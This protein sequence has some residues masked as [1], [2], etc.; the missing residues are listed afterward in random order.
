MGLVDTLVNK[1]E[2]G[3]KL[4]QKLLQIYNFVDD[5]IY[6]IAIVIALACALILFSTSCT[7]AE[8]TLPSAV[9]YSVNTTEWE[10]HITSTIAHG[11]EGDIVGD[12]DTQELENK[13][14]TSSILKGTFTNSGTVSLPD[15]TLDGRT[16]DLVDDNLFFITTGVNDGLRITSTNT[17]SYGSSISLSHD[18]STPSHGNYCGSINFNTTNTADEMEHFGRISCIAPIVTDGIEYGKLLWQLREP[19]GSWNDAMT[20][21]YNGTLEVDAGFGTFDEYDDAELLREGIGNDDKQLLI[22]IGVLV[23]SQPYINEQGEIVSGNYK[24]NIQNMLKL[25]SGGVYQNR[26]KIDELEARIEALEARLK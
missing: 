2:R 3:L 19:S 25:L 20:L 5:W 15:F 23:K 10:E 7:I 16:I 4:K 11:T 18:D 24:F 12:N 22:D 21:S 14:L 9:V 1:K 8:P 26:D 6:Y 13:T 17:G